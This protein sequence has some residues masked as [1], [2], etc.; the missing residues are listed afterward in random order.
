MDSKSLP[1]ALAEWAAI[2]GSAHVT[3]SPET[4]SAAA[5]ATFATR[6]PTRTRRTALFRDDAV[7]WLGI[8]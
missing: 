3:S 1:A 4:L 2:V 6:I 7:M 8:G 5:T